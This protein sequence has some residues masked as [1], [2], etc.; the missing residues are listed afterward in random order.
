MTGLLGDMLILI[1][2]KDASEN[3][4]SNFGSKLK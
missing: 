3:N 4:V 2:I 1:N